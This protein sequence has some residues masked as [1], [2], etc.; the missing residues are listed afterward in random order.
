MTTTETEEHL[1]LVDGRG[2]VLLVE[3]PLAPDARPVSPPP[4]RIDVGGPLDLAADPSDPV[5][6]RRMSPRVASRTGWTPW[7][8]HDGVL[9]VAALASVAAEPASLTA[10]GA[11]ARDLVPGTEEVL[12]RTVEP[13]ALAAALETAHSDRLAVESAQQLALRH[14]QA[15]AA[16]GLTTWQ[17]AMPIVAIGVLVG[18]L[19]VTPISTLVIVLA[20]ANVVF[21]TNVVFKAA[22]AL[23]APVRRYRHAARTLKEMRLRTEAGLPAVWDPFDSDD[24]LPPYTVLVPAYQEANVVHKVIANLSAL[25]YPHDKLDVMLLLEAD[26]E[27]TI[28]AARGLPMPDFMRVVVVPPGTPQTKP[29]ACNYGLGLAS[30]QYVVI[31]DAED[32]PDPDQLRKAV[33]EFARDDFE[34]RHGLTDKPPLAVVQASLHYFNADYNV[35][36]RMFA[37]E[38]AHWFEAML[39]GLSSIGL[40]LPLGGTS[41]HFDTGILRAMGGWDPYNV[42]EDADAG[43]RASTEGYRVS[44]IDSSTGEE[45][46]AITKS[47]IK[48]R[49]RWIKGYLMTAAVNTRRPVH[50]LQTAGPGGLV[51]LLGLIVATPLAFLAYPLA[52]GLTL[53][54]WIGVRFIGV[55]LPSWVLSTSVTTFIAGN[56]LMIASAAAAAT[57]RY[58]WRIGIFAVFSPVYWLLH[59]IA[60]WRALYQVVVDPHRWEKTPHGLT[61]DY[62][63]EAHVR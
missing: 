34:Q 35:L 62:E 52:L 12:V 38:Y 44:V 7:S 33:M 51:G 11:V 29:R 14:P 26:D 1:R 56:A 53:T 21:L 8:L 45:A 5:V 36:T 30:G 4:P 46:C 24:D 54:T 63:S 50:F 27:E 41:N 3:S 28:E 37:V 48:Q 25:D 17:R 22:A 16:T 55:Q 15:S 58:N 40:P 18:F 59:S 13:A 61:H 6:V 57:W 10:A 39:P 47:W 32:R 49:T 60:A 42:T 9:T 19:L 2:S 43:L 20:L 31:F 23:V